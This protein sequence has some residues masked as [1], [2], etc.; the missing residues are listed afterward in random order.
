VG[1]FLPPLLTC[2]SF[3][4]RSRDNRNLA[5]FCNRHIDAEIA[6]ARAL[7]VADPGA[8][9]RIWRRVDHDVVRLA[10]WVFMQNELQT[11]LVSRR[12]GNYQYNPQWGPLLDQLWVR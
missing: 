9:S 7:E 10:P 6:R 12:V 4:P 2:K 5:E 3:V 8:A 1:G 11:T